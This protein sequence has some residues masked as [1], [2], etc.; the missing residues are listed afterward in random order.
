RSTYFSTPSSMT[1]EAYSFWNGTLFN[2][3]KSKD[4]RREIDVSYE[5]LAGG[6][7]C[8]DKQF[9]QIVNIE[10]LAEL[11]VLAEQFRQIVNIEDALR[12]GCDLFD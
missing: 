6:V 8:E 4:R 2:T 7:L 12:G 5:R 1:H 9:R 11:L 10:D 3:G